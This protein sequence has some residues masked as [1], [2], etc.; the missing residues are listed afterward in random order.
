LFAV[1]TLLNG[2]MLIV[3]LPGDKAEKIHFFV[4]GCRPSLLLPKKTLCSNFF[5]DS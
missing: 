5:L 3:T 2:R 4:F 1:L